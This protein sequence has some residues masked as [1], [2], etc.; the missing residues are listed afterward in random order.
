MQAFAALVERYRDSAYGVALHVLGDSAEAAEIAQDAFVKAY[1]SLSQLREPSR[2]AAWL[3]TIAMNLARNRRR[4]RQALPV[5]ASLDAVDEIEDSELA[6]PDAMAMDE[7]GRLVRHLMAKLP[8]SQRLT[9][10]L[11]YVDGYSEDDLSNMLDVP[12]GT[13]KSRLSRARSRLREEVVK[14]AEDVLKESRPDADFWRSTTGAA[15]GRV[16]DAATGEPVADVHVSLCIWDTATFAGTRSDAEGVW[17]AEQLVPGPYTVTVRHP[18]FV[19]AH[20]LHVGETN[21]CTPVVIRPG[22]TVQ[23]ID[24]EMTRGAV[25]AGVVVN[26]SNSP[27]P[28]ATVFAWSRRSTKHQRFGWF[29]QKARLYVDGDGRFRIGNLARGRYVFGALA[30]ERDDYA[31]FRPMSYYPGTFCAEEAEWVDV[32]PDVPIEGLVLPMTA[33]GSV[34][35]TVRVVDAETREP[36]GGARV[37][38]NR[39]DPSSDRFTG[40][41]DETGCYRS[42][43]LT[44]GTF[45][46]TAGHEDRGYP[47]WS[48]WL[49]VTCDD[50]AAEVEFELPK[51]V[52]FQG[53][54]VT[55]DGEALPSLDYFVVS[56][57]PERSS[58]SDSRNGGWLGIG[59]GKGPGVPHYGL[60]LREGPQ[61]ETMDI[62]ADGAM[63]SPA[64]APGKVVVSTH[65]RDEGW[66]AISVALDGRPLSAGESIECNPGDRVSGLEVVIGTNLGVVAGRVVSAADGKPLEGIWVHLHSSDP[67]QTDTPSAC[68]SYNTRTDRSGSFFFH[69]VPA[70]KQIVWEGNASGKRQGKHKAREI[71][72]EPGGT[73]HLDLVATDP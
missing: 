31:Y 17:R 2:F 62:A 50:E 59:P 65:V 12:T 30:G 15:E 67:E 18:D 52:R 1:R 35:L 36:I 70:G 8:D 32:S 6:P 4:A 49:E 55:R 11:Y 71:E 25:V 3:R 37:L 54:I 66:R 42:G 56:L 60:S 57:T 28:G 48:K 40:H 63:S 69:A 34:R 14:M 27:T 73:V 33:K 10:T 26:E 7:I 20:Y 38:V 22:Q 39:L 64:L 53:A 46:V 41:T 43:Q 61:S 47:R 9:F 29:E 68:S 13:I 21:V 19:S 44:A 58:E 16:M 23:G 5:L 24:F 45:L 51:G 72:V